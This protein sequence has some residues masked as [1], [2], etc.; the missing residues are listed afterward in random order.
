[1]EAVWVILGV[2]FLLGGIAGSVL[3]VIPGPPISFVGVL[4]FQ[5]TDKVSIDTNWL[6]ILALGALVITILDY[7]IPS[8]FTKKY[9]AH[10]LS[11]VMAFVGMCIGIFFFPPFGLIIGPFIGAFVGEIIIGRVWQQGFKS[12]WAT[13]VGFIFG[14]ML[15]LVY[16]GFVIIVVL[17]AYFSGESD[18][19]DVLAVLM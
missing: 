13:F 12:A 9:G 4:F 18:P 15:K 11:S 2:L 3:P 19:G 8:Y 16:A 6:W 10:W 17:R 1:M 14:T 7:I 5:Q